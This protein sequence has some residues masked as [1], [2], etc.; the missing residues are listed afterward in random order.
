MSGSNILHVQF[1]DVGDEFDLSQLVVAE[2]PTFTANGKTVDYVLSGFSKTT[3]GGSSPNYTTRSILTPK[4]FEYGKT[5][6]VIRAMWMSN[7]IVQFQSDDSST[8]GHMNPIVVVPGK[9]TSVPTCGYEY[10]KEEPVY[11]YYDDDSWQPTGG[12]TSPNVKTKRFSGWNYSL[13]NTTY[14]LY[15]GKNFTPPVV[16][17]MDNPPVLTFRA[18]WEASV[19][20]VKFNVQEKLYCGVLIDNKMNRM[21]VPQHNPQLVDPE[22]KFGGWMIPNGS[23][24][25]GVDSNEF[26]ICGEDTEPIVCGDTLEPIVCENGE[27]PEY[28]IV[29]EAVVVEVKNSI[30]N[31]VFK[32]MDVD[33]TRTEQGFDV[34]QNCRIP[35]FHIQNNYTKDGHKFR[36]RYWLL[37]SGNLSS[38]FTVLSDLVFVAVYDDVVELNLESSESAIVGEQQ[39]EGESTQIEDSTTSFQGC[40]HLIEFSG[41]GQFGCGLCGLDPTASDGHFEELW[42]CPYVKLLVDMYGEPTGKEQENDF[43]QLSIMDIRDVENLLNALFKINLDIAHK[44]YFLKIDVPEPS[45]WWYGYTTGSDIM[46]IGEGDKVVCEQAGSEDKIVCE[47]PDDSQ[48]WHNPNDKKWISF[49]PTIELKFSN[50]HAANQV[51]G[52]RLICTSGEYAQGR[53][54]P[55]NV[56]ITGVQYNDFHYFY[57]YKK[58]WLGVNKTVASGAGQ[59]QRLHPKLADEQMMYVIN[60]ICLYENTSVQS[61]TDINDFIRHKLNPIARTNKQ[62]QTFTSIVKKYRPV[63]MPQVRDIF[64]DCQGQTLKCDCDEKNDYGVFGWC[65]IPSKTMVDMEYN[66]GAL[67]VPSSYDHHNHVC[68]SNFL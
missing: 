14:T 66:E 42:N 19:Y 11:T 43:R 62:V 59:S 63:A 26:V 36:F 37:E 56:E 60:P 31:V 35:N 46:C 6:M 47:R 5:T 33:G 54:C 23:Y 13:G 44:E 39:V 1:G 34:V 32:Y 49:E 48:V 45:N 65:S 16:Y 40:E 30:L 10:A 29:N 55:V 51:Q 18:M 67:Y 7:Y 52:D 53:I 57:D 27:M 50:F 3:S 61:P 28:G 25:G 20:K 58:E 4:S 21:V 2:N 9:L 15:P 24:I 64:D 41:E 8:S 17:N 22:L 38:S 12:Y 68:G